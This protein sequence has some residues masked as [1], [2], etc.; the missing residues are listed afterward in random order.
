M[1]T[2]GGEGRFAEPGVHDRGRRPRPAR[3]LR[4]LFHLDVAQA[5]HHAEHLVQHLAAV[6]LRDVVRMGADRAVLVVRRHGVERALPGDRRGRDLPEATARWNRP[7]E[8]SHSGRH[9]LAEGDCDGSAL[10]FQVT[11]QLLLEL[12]PVRHRTTPFGLGFTL[13]ASCSNRGRRWNMSA[14]GGNHRGDEGAVRPGHDS[15]T[16]YRPDVHEQGT[17]PRRAR[18]GHD[19]GRRAGFSS[20]PRTGAARRSRR[21]RS[22]SSWPRRP[23]A[24]RCGSSCA[25]RTPT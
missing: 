13:G 25:T 4:D 15:A 3:D 17:V 21:C 16:V 6:G 14:A 12:C 23:R 10:Q 8:L 5:R 11:R 22:S 1:T 20:S 9:R 7:V 2:S 19:R 24:S 18:L